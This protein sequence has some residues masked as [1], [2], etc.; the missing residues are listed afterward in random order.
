MKVLKIK[1]ATAQGYIEV[2][3]GGVFDIAYP[4]SKSRRGRVQGNGNISPALT[5]HSNLVV[6]EDTIYSK[7]DK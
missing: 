6:Y 4:N 1:Q 7:P 3:Q 5:C 2:Q